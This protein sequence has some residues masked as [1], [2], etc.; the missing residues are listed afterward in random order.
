MPLLRHAATSAQR[1]GH[2]ERVETEGVPVDAA[3]GLRQRRRLAVGDHDDLPHVLPLALEDPAREPQPLA[4][5]RVVRPDAHASELGERDL[6][7]RIME[8]HHLQRIA[9]I[10]RLDQL[11]QRQR[12]TLGRRE[13]ILAVEDHA[14]AAVEHQHRRARA[15]I[16]ALHDHQIFVVVTSMPAPCGRSG[17]TGC[18]RLALRASRCTAFSSVRAGVEIQRVA[19][20][21]RLRRAGVSTPVA[22]S[23][24]SWRPKLLLPSDPSRSRSARYPG[25]RASCR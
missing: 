12:D 4:R 5:V 1:L 15:L 24:V 11:R 9:G 22:C 19:E 2:D 16:L 17:G 21:V 13:A 7:G 23:R 18:R 25:S 3:V 6:L 8:Q 10:L 14:V 20:L